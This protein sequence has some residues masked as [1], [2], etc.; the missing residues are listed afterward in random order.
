MQKIIENIPETESNAIWDNKDQ[1]T[2]DKIVYKRI[3]SLETKIK[4]FFKLAGNNFG[5]TQRID[6]PNYESWKNVTY[7][8]GRGLHPAP[9]LPIQSR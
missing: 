7:T 4:N 9:E 1:E 8:P 6:H 5:T 3:C 2:I